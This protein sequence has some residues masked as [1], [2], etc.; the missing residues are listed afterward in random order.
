MP[1]SLLLEAFAQTGTILIETGSGFT[2]KAFPAFIENAKFR[3]PV[4][5]GSELR[6]EMRVSSGAD[7]S[8]LLTGRIVQAGVACCSATIGFATAP[9][10]EFFAPEHREGYRALYRSWLDGAELGGFARSPL[11]ELVHALD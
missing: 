3:R 5:P 7:D 2:R 6:I 1:A 10:A 9:L 8:V 11:E 4:I